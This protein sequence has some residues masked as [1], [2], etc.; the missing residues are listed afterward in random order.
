[1]T[2]CIVAVLSRKIVVPVTGEPAYIVQEAEAERFGDATPVVLAMDMMHS[3]FPNAL[4]FEIY[5]PITDASAQ[6]RY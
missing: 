2:V 4:S 5:R 3:K 1:M 6:T